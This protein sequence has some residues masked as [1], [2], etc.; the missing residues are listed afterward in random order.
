MN[1]KINDIDLWYEK[2]G[3]G[4]SFILLHG[5]GESH[6]IFDMLIEELSKNFTVYAIDSRDHGKSTKINK[7]SYK[8]MV[9]DVFSFINE[10]KIEKPIL[11]GFSDGGIVG[12]LLASDYPDLLSRLIVSGANTNPDGV[13]KPWS[14]IFKILYLIF[15][16]DKFRMMVEEPDISREDLKKI[17][18]PVLVLAGEK[19]LIKEKNTK[20]I[21]ENIS[22]ST[23]K[24]LEKENHMSYVVHSPKLY[25]IIEPFIN[26]I[27]NI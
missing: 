15:R 10:L 12:L 2:R 6:E 25:K 20:F 17:N 14:I 9:E 11:Y 26:D 18:I 23:L 19:D 4:Q 1:I 16:Q 8:M 5:N 7:L 21:A 3:S 27:E 13:K 22:D 24:I